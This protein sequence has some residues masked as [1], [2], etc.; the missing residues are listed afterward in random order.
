MAAREI[1]HKRI[2]DAVVRV[3]AERGV[4]GASVELVIVRAGVSRRAFYECYGGLDECLVTVM[5]RTLERV[6]VLAWRAFEREG[7]WLD[8]MRGALAAVFEFF[9]SEP[10]LARVC[11]V[12]TLGGDPVVMAQRERVVGAFRALVVAR[13]EG[14]VSPVSPLAAEGVLASVMGLARACLLAPNPSR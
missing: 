9:D 6:S 7:D 13:I 11:L 14:E 3:V 2:L 5:D 12:E 8:G 10:A 1:Q 4:A